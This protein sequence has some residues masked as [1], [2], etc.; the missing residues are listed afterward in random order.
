MAGARRFLVRKRHD[1]YSLMSR[2]HKPCNEKWSVVILLPARLGEMADDV[3]CLGRAGD[4][5]VFS[6]LTGCGRGITTQ[7]SEHIQRSKIV[8]SSR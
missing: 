3:Q 1:G 5:A 4:S 8:D 7:M 2:M 6:S